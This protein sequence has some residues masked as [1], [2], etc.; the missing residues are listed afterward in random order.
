LVSPAH[1][2]SSSEFFVRHVQIALRLL[3]AGVSEH[4]LDDPDVHAIGQEATRAF[5]PQVVPS[6]IDLSQLLLVLLD[7]LGS[8][9]QRVAVGEELQR[10]PGEQYQRMRCVSDY[11]SHRSSKDWRFVLPN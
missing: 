1:L 11:L 3:N 8:A 9:L 7:A 2:Q 10:F 5:V 6:Q 4:Q